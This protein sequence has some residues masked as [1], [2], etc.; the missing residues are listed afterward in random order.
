[1]N[2]SFAPECC[3]AFTR[4]PFRDFHPRFLD[5]LASCAR[6]PTPEQYDELA[7]RVPRASDAQVPRFVT[8]NRATLRQAGGYEQHVAQLRA[9]PTRRN[10]WH[11]FF[12]MTVW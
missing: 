7:A 2:P 3:S 1:M 9:V 11:D 12:N 4:L 6:W 8:E 5:A 10:H